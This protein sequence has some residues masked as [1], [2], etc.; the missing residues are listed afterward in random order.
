M[1]R[2]EALHNVRQVGRVAASGSGDDPAKAPKARRARPA[3]IGAGH[4]GPD[5]ASRAKDVLR[6]EMG[7]R[8][9]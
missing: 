4:L 9:A 2:D 6:D 5:F 7:Q 1:S 3:W 8:D